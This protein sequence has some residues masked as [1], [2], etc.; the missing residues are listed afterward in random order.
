MTIRPAQTKDIPRIYQLLQQ[1]LAVHH[2]ARPDLFKAQGSKLSPE[3]ISEIIKDETQPF[4]VFV[5]EKDEILGYIICQI[6]VQTGEVLQPIKTLFI[7]DLCV[8]EAARGQK[9]GLKLYQHVKDYAKSTHC[10]NLT[11][12]VW[13]D[14]VK[15]LAFYERLGLRPLYTQLEEKL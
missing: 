3:Q 1:I 7:D 12:N 9:I 11:L 5:D 13:N 15:A 14:N 4:F 10:Y 6:K 8:D 2:K